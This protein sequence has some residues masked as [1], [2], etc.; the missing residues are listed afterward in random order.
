MNSYANRCANT[1]EETFYE[2]RDKVDWVYKAAKNQS[3]FLSF[4]VSEPFNGSRFII[5]NANRVLNDDEVS[6]DFSKVIGKT[7]PITFEKSWLLHHR[8]YAI[9]IDK[10]A[11]DKKRLVLYTPNQHHEAPKVSS[12]SI[13]WRFA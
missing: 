12:Q 6:H 1:L 8:L 4:S 2:S 11:N 3:L 5:N 13:G 7:C 9:G 10:T